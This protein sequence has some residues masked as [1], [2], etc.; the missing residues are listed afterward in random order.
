MPRDLEIGSTRQKP[1]RGDDRKTHWHR[2]PVSPTQSV[3]AS[4]AAQSSL[5]SNSS[6]ALEITGAVG[7]V[8]EY[9]A[10]VG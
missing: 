5:V 9:V 10:S 8:R 1:P 2:S 4:C 6:A 3:Y 7:D